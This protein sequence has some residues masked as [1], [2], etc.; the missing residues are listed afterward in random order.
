MNC[1]RTEFI[2]SF[3]RIM[4]DG[5]KRVCLK[6]SNT[7]IVSIVIIEHLK[8]ICLNEWIATVTFRFFRLSIGV[9]Q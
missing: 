9:E 5:F 1:E 2:I 8:D 7:V 3:L 6:I 4:S